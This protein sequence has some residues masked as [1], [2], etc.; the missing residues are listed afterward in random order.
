MHHHDINHQ[1]LKKHQSK[2]PDFM[3]ND[4]NNQNRQIYHQPLDE[5]KLVEIKDNILKEAKDLS[6]SVVQNMVNENEQDV[7]ND[8]NCKSNSSS[9]I[10]SVYSPQKNQKWPLQQQAHKQSDLNIG[11]SQKSNRVI[12]RISNNLVKSDNSCISENKNVPITSFMQASVFNGRFC[13]MARE[14]NSII[15][16]QSSMS[17]QRSA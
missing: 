8:R 3:S 10:S 5:Q 1:N 4:H 17:D 15:G 9:N 14:V 13:N 6:I 2:R 16:G 11:Q 12:N 7:Q